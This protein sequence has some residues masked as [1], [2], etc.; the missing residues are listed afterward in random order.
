MASESTWSKPTALAIPKAVLDIGSGLHF[1]YM[2]ISDNYTG[3]A[4][5]LFSATATVYTNVEGFP[6][7]W[8]KTRKHSS[9]SST[10]TYKTLRL[11]GPVVSPG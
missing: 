3:D 2:G 7:D 9:S 4:I 6:E 8:K 1:Q 11:P 10:I 5:K